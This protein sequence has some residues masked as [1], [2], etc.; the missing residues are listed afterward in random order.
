MLKVSNIIN[1]KFSFFF[2]HLIHNIL[3]MISW[4]LDELRL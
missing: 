3:K 1:V 4:M 2:I